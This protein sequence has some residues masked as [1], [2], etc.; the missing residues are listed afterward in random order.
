MFRTSQLVI[1]HRIPKDLNMKRR[2][3]SLAAGTLAAAAFVLPQVANAGLI[4]DSSVILTGQGFGNAPRDLTLQ[5]TG[6]QT[7]ESGAVGVSSTGGITFGT[8]IPDASVSPGNGI[9]NSTST[10]AMPSPLADDQKYGVPTTGSLG[11]TSASQIGVL[12]NAT[13]PGGN[14]VNVTDLTL[15][16]YTANGT[17]LGAIDGQQNFGSTNPGNG[18]AGFVFVVDTAQ[19]GFVN[20]LLTQGG[21]GTRL[22]LEASIA[23]FAG[24]PESFLIF[25]RGLTGGTVGPTGSP[26]PEPGTLAIFGLGLLGF[27]VAR[28]RR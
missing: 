15:K 27:L 9:T 17:L 28:R 11:I 24:G 20:G 7:T 3:L 4:Y 1:T 16:F 12:F 23:D 19:Q 8:A 10:A 18:V 13:E 26:V 6:Q 22:A 25:N 5:A 21:S 2:L 14:S